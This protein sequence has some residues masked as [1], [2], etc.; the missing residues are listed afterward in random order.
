MEDLEKLQKTA[1]NKKEKLPN[2]QS[3]NDKD[4]EL[5]SGGMNIDNSIENDK[6]LNSVS[7]DASKSDRDKLKSNL[8]TANGYLNKANKFLDFFMD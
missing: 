1:E 8:K 3:L 4:L 7:D 5:V 2:T 6:D